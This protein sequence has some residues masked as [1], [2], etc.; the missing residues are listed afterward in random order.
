MHSYETVV[1]ALEGLKARGYI[2]NFNI[3]FDKISCSENDICLNPDEF[4]IVEVY[5]FEGDSNPEDE[6][7]VYAVQSR[8]GGNKGVITSAYGL[9]A[10]G[11]SDGIIQKLSIHPKP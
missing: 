11:V 9:Y 4:E 6:D 8:D 5:R 10:D 7:V 2:L 3:A 1:A